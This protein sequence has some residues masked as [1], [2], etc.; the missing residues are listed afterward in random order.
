MNLIWRIGD[1]LIDIYMILIIVTAFLS[2]IPPLYDSRIGKFLRQ[3]TEPS[4]EMVRKYIPPILG[5]D[6]SPV[7]VLVLCEVLKRL[8]FFL[9]NVLI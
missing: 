3:F 8:W 9:F 7:I 5:L 6:F 2:W 4:S 1:R